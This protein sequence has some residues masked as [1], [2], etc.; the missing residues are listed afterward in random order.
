[1]NTDPQLSSLF[2]KDIVAFI[3]EE[4]LLHRLGH[5]QLAIQN[6]ELFEK[7]LKPFIWE[8]WSWYD[9]GW[10][11]FKDKISR[12]LDGD[13][14]KGFTLPFLLMPY[15][16]VHEKEFETEGITALTTVEENRKWHIA[17]PGEQYKVLLH[18]IEMIKELG[19]KEQKYIL[20]SYF[21]SQIPDEGKEIYQ[22]E[23]NVDSE[24]IIIMKIHKGK[25]VPCFEEAQVISGWIE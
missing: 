5:S 9:G 21:T 2:D 22:L 25:W 15:N 20:N 4:N 14:I 12:L 8:G 19:V 24:G 6:Q 17:F 18:L 16:E 7:Y 10:G 23:I 11:E 1:M 13:P 3:P